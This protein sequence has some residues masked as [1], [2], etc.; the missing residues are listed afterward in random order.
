VDRKD[1]DKKAS[2]GSPYQLLLTPFGRKGVGGY[3]ESLREFMKSEIK[4]VESARHGKA[5]KGAK[6]M[7]SYQVRE[8]NGDGS[9]TLH[10]QFPFLVGNQYS[11]SRAYIKA[12][13]FADTL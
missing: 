12:C 1:E 13:N 11:K 9:Y 7:S 4:V 3:A 6:K 5:V 2:T 10:K 8:D